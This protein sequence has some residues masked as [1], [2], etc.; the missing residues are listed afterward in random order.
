MHISKTKLF[1]YSVIRIIKKFVKILT[2]IFNSNFSRI[3]QF[4][5]YSQ[6]IK[7]IHAFYTRIFLHDF[8]TIQKTMHLPHKLNLYK[9]KTFT[10]KFGRLAVSVATSRV[11]T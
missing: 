2:R 4:F 7:T 6:Y 8:R 5:K 3:I 1:Y 11:T 10:A 9:K